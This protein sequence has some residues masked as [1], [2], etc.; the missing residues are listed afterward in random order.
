[1]SGPTVGGTA[2]EMPLRDHS[3]PTTASSRFSSGSKLHEPE[4]P[5]YKYTAGIAISS[6][7]TFPRPTADPLDQELSRLKEA[8]DDRR[9][10]SHNMIIFSETEGSRKGSGTVLAG[11]LPILGALISIRDKILEVASSEPVATRSRP[12][13][14]PFGIAGDAILTAQKLWHS[15]QSIHENTHGHMLPAERIRAVARLVDLVLESARVKAKAWKGLGD[16]DRKIDR[17]LDGREP[18]D[19]AIARRETLRKASRKFALLTS[20]Q[21]HELQEA[22]SPEPKY[23]EMKQSGWKQVQR[24]SR[25][26]IS[27]STPKKKTAQ[28]AVAQQHSMSTPQPA[29]Y[30]N[31]FELPAD[32]ESDLRARHNAP[33]RTLSAKGPS[34]ATPRALKDEQNDLQNELSSRRASSFAESRRPSL[35]SEGALSQ[36]S[37]VVKELAAVETYPGPRSELTCLK[38][39]YNPGRHVAV[40]PL[41]FRGIAEDARFQYR[42]DIYSSSSSD[43][44]MERS[45]SP[46]DYTDYGSQRITLPIMRPRTPDIVDNLLAEWTTLPR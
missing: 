14:S 7:E 13:G 39:V 2:V 25:S 44:Y 33:E 31:V 37:Y 38:E 43:D 4:P 41:G 11:D 19:E 1:M 28:R 27:L 32:N 6:E 30:S 15:V 40:A 3:R 21:R 23:K 24:L 10:K 8:L 16:V 9:D 36:G 29:E 42:R 5:K 34:Y 12:T 26:I 46:G 22:W 17:I 35:D 20:S 45:A 18:Q